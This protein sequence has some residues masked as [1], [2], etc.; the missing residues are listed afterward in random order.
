MQVLTSNIKR[1]LDLRYNKG[2]SRDCA[3]L[4]K[5]K[6]M[7]Q[8]EHTDVT[9]VN[10]VK[11]GNTRAYELLVLKYQSRIHALVY[12]VIG[13]YDESLDVTQE[14]FVRAYKA[15]QSFRG[16]SQFYTW[17]YR[18][19]INTA[20]NLLQNKSRQV[21]CNQVDTEVL[22]YIDSSNTQPFAISP[23]STSP[24]REY[25]ANDLKK[26]VEKAI[27]DLPSDFKTALTLREIEGLS[28][29]EISEV[30]Q[31]PVGTVRSRIFRARES[32]QKIIQQW[33]KGD[34]V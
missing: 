26:V 25:E 7:V 12:K 13:D 29:D 5:E 4:N 2:N 33:R 23:T 15:I 22:E 18:I 31:S 21:V 8:P 1:S 24:D 9:L 14:V 6:S 30:T 11:E 20:K 17:L 3:L 27:N 16:D 34:K 10:L 28:Y 19:A 32:V